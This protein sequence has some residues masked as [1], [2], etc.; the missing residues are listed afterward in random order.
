MNNSALPPGPR[1]LPIL[2]C[3]PALM[4][5]RLGFF[6]A[7]ARDF[8]DVSSFPVPVR[9]PIFFVNRPDL[10]RRVLVEDQG[11]FVKSAQYDV[12]KLVL[13]EGLLIS[14][15]EFHRRQRRMIQPAFHRKQVA[16]YGAI[17]TEYG[18]RTREHWREGEAVDLNREMMRVTLEIIA[19]TMFESEV[20][21]EAA[22]IGRA[23]GLLMPKFDNPLVIV[24]PRLFAMLPGN[25]TYLEAVERLN[26]TVHRIIDD[27]RRSK[28]D[29][30]DLLSMLLQA[31]DTD[32]G[33]TQMSQ[34]QIRDEVMTIF[35]AGHET[36]ALWLTWTWYLLAQNPAVEAKLHQELDAA[37]EGRPPSLEEVPRLKYTQMVLEESLRLY[38]PAWSVGRSTVVDYRLDGYLAPAGANVVMSPY[39]IQRDPRYFA[40]PLKF[41]PERW[42]DEARARRPEFCFFPF[43]GG[44]RTCIG[45]SFARLEAVLLLASFAQE[46]SF[47]VAPGH[48]LELLPMVTLRPKGGLPGVLYRRVKPSGASRAVA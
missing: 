15:G 1:G 47:R 41:D 12:L 46:W 42:T 2:G 27:R 33:G 8:G 11:C 10:I 25:R 13:G 20:E 29:R 26:S 43:G 19:R 31:R 38:P 37:L 24:A 28:T 21:E 4:R 30:G 45:E 48:R 14:E 34:Q 39:V 36:T 9:G 32:D 23:I 3:L 7:L 5:D 6:A 22:E 35:L 44:P 16:R 18:L 40:E 17:M